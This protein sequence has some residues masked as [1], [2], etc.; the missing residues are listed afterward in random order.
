VRKDPRVRPDGLCAREGCGRRRPITVASGKKRAQLARYA[1]LRQ[2]EED[3]FCS[4]VCCRLYH[5]CPLPDNGCTP[6][7]LEAR[8]AA[9]RAGKARSGLSRGS[10]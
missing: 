10:A 5:G 2:L 3:P 1:G 4:T 7:Q 9:G 8:S 6:A